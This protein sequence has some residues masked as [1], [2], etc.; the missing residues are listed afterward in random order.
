MSHNSSSLPRAILSAT[1]RY[2]GVPA[3]RGV[4]S[5]SS[6]SRSNINGGSWSCWLPV[7]PPHASAAPGMGQRCVLVYFFSCVTFLSQMIILTISHHLWRMLL[8][9]ISFYIQIPPLQKS[10]C[11][12]L[13]F[14]ILQRE[15]VCWEPH[16]HNVLH[17][18]QHGGGALLD[19]FI[20]LNMSTNITSFI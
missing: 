10:S 9:R 12:H 4:S 8:S 2:S 13:T 20:L 3:S 7:A 17:T 1:A 14:K 11:S 5:A 15:H 18:I 19:H 6:R 16:W